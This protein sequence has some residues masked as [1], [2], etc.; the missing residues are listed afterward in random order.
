MTELKHEIAVVNG[1]RLHYVRAGK[2][3]PVLLVHGWPQT[4][5]EWHRVIP[6]LVAGGHEI[7]ALDMR[8]SGDSDKPASGYDSNTVADDLHELVRHLGFENIRVVAHD[9]GARVAYAYAARYRDEVKSLVFLESKIL[10]IESD[11]DAEKEYWHF[12]FHQAPD[13]AQLLVVGR[14]REYLSYF[15]KTY[16]WDPTAITPSDLDEFVRCY[17]APG[18]L[19]GGF[20]FY[21]AFPESARQ[22]RELASHKLDI[23]VLA[24]GG[25]HCMGDISYRSMQQV[26]NNV[27]GGVIP[28][29]GHWIPEEKPE[30]IAREILAFH[31]KHS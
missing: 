16:A 21:K 23:P 1:V 11:D 14:E 5:Y 2:G 27:E 20:E 7:I 28:E 22:S 26:A 6:H 13:L 18:G 15:F 10:G 9:N 3:E 8:G 12:G 4:W 29:C 31:N 30:F 24:W 19:R 17:A 25:A